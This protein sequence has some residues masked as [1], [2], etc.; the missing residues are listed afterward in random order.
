MRNYRLLFNNNKPWNPLILKT[1]ADPILIVASVL[2][3]DTRAYPNIDEF[4]YFG[5]QVVRAGL[6]LRDEDG[7][8]T[9]EGDE[10]L[11]EQLEI[12]KWR[13]TTMCID[14]ALG[15]DDFETAYSF[16]T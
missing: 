8:S 13:I 5:E 16:V 11:Q 9:L 15:E 7:N 12:A 14:A 4:L 1:H 6:T 3:Q 10:Q 2:S